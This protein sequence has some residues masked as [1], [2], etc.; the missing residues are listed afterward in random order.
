M[1]CS[2]CKGVGHN[3]RTCGRKRV[4]CPSSDECPVCLTGYECDDKKFTTI[5]CNHTFC[6]ECVEHMYESRIDT[7][8]LCRGEHKH[9]YKERQFPVRPA[10]AFQIMSLELETLLNEI[11]PILDRFE[12]NL[13]GEITSDEEMMEIISSGGELPR[14]S[15]M[16]QRERALLDT[17]VIL[18]L[19]EIMENISSGG[20]DFPIF[21]SH[22]RM[23]ESFLERASVFRKILFLLDYMMD[24]LDELEFNPEI[25][26]TAFRI[27]NIANIA[28]IANH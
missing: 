2:K 10:A 8:P 1:P 12:E 6:L 9:A 22:L 5:Y 26:I 21:S 15:Q 25:M 19:S 16:F 28:N 13:F 4:V 3:A 23:F 27:E 20:E 17:N 11:V 24:K 7:C 14:L 18:R